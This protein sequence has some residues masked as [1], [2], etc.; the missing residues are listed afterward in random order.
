MY[1]RSECIGLWGYSKSIVHLW[2]CEKK[3][4]WLS[5]FFSTTLHQNMNHISTL[6]ITQLDIESGFTL[7][8]TFIDSLLDAQNIL[9]ITIHI[10]LSCL[11]NCYGKL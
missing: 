3:F 6:I 7:L 5:K 10:L 4:H 8:S 11:S 2:R 9:T 1:L